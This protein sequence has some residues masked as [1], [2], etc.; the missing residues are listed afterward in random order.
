MREPVSFSFILTKEDGAR[1][2]GSAIVFDEEFPTDLSDQVR[3][4]FAF[5]F[6]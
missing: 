5:C 6:T 2:Y 3:E 4:K 1:I